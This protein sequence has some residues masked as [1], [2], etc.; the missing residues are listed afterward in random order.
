LR[1][2]PNRSYRPPVENVQS[3]APFLPGFEPRTTTL[4]PSEGSFEPENER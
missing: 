4:N 3:D 1:P 2:F